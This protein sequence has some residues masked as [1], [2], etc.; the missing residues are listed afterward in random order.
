MAARRQGRQAHHQLIALAPGPLA[1]AQG[2]G[3]IY[4]HCHMGAEAQG[5]GIHQRPVAQPQPQLPVTAS[6]EAVGDWR[7]DLQLG[8]A[9]GQGRRQL[10]H[11]RRR[12]HLLQAAGR[13]DGGQQIWIV[14]RRAGAATA[15]Q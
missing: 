13:G 5:S 14:G 10:P 11:G 4:L 8:R 7:L 1:E 3:V 12:R 9:L 6:Q 15:Y 2:W